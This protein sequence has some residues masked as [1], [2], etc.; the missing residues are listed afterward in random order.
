MSPVI[1]V[2]KSVHYSVVLRYFLGKACRWYWKH[3]FGTICNEGG[4]N[5]SRVGFFALF[6]G[7][8]QHICIHGLLI[9]FDFYLLFSDCLRIY[10]TQSKEVC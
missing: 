7:R 4:L 5:F 10:L 2:V 6:G 1:H 9:T 8:L 3:T